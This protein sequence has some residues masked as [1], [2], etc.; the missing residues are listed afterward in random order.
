MA[1]FGSCVDGWSE[2]ESFSLTHESELHTG[3]EERRVKN[4]VV[5]VEIDGVVTNRLVKAETAEEAERKVMEE[6]K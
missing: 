5:T 6:K 3:K 1:P 2:D 4:Y